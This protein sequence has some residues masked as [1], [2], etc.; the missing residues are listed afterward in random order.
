MTEW[1]GPVHD[2]PADLPI[3]ASHD[4]F[5]GAIWDVRTDEV[6]IAGQVVNRDIMV[7]PGAV[8]VIAMD[9][10]ERVLLLRQYRHPVG[11]YLFEPPAGLLDDPEESPLTAARRELVEEAG[12][13]ARQWHHLVDFANSPGGS[14]ETF[15]CFLA[16]EVAPA[17]GGRQLTGEAEEMD[18]P[19]VWVPLSQAR[20]LVFAGALQNPTTVIG[21]LAAWSARANGWDTLKPPEIPWP[22]RAHVVSAGRVARKQPR[23]G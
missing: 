16:R 19:A 9:D 20:D 17:S 3:R 11:A 14:S 6:E 4:V 13:V 15:R 21:I 2:E 7:H 23:H 12:L 10:D 18:M 5:T 22:M 8:G 1:S